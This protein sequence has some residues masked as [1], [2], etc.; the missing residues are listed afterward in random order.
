[1]SPLLSFK[2]TAAAC[3]LFFGLNEN[4]NILMAIAGTKA[5][6]TV[7]CG[8]TIHIRLG[9]GFVCIMRQTMRVQGTPSTAATQYN[10]FALTKQRNFC[11]PRAN[12]SPVG[13]KNGNL[14]FFPRNKP[15][16]ALPAFVLP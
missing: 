6:Q 15:V 7:P 12:R 4:F 13:Y 8:R 1:M 2:R 9:F 10:L 14:Q 5:F 3:V 16:L 11:I